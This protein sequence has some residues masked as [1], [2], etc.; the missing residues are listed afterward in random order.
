M[1]EY[2]DAMAT[3]RGPKWLALFSSIPGSLD[4]KLLLIFR[5][6]LS[7]SSV[8]FVVGSHHWLISNPSDLYRVVVIKVFST[9]HLLGVQHRDAAERKMLYKGDKGY[10]IDFEH[11]TDT[12]ICSVK[13]PEMNSI[14]QDP[15]DF[16]C[17]ELWRRLTELGLWRPGTGYCSLLSSL[18]ILTYFNL[19]YSYH[20]LCR[21]ISTR[22]YHAHA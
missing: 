15:S 3:S 19:L 11:A 5:I 21:R 6:G 13:C 14:A 18:A 16:P 8:I 10:L 4:V 9:I 17:Q 1:N 2:P 7:R 22:Q 12:H 20:L